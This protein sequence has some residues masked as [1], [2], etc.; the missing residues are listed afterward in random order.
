MVDMGKHVYFHITMCLCATASCREGT[1]DIG[2]RA[3]ECAQVF[4]PH[5]CLRVRAFKSVCV[6]VPAATLQPAAA[7]AKLGAAG[8]KEPAAGGSAASVGV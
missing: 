7:G 2:V 6:F 3:P 5:C 4:V 8:E 1:Y